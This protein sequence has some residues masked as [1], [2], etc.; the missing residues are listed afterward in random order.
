[1]TLFLFFLQKEM[2]QTPAAEY[3]FNENV[4]DLAIPSVATLPTNSQVICRGNGNSL[5]YW[6]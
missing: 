2:N 3:E 4:T 1:M 6:M 5:T